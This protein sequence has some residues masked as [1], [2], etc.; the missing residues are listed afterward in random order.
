MSTTTN[1][2]IEKLKSMTLL[3]ASE[4]VSQ[5]EQTFGVDASAP[6]GGNFIQSQG[7]GGSSAQEAQEEKTTFDVILESIP[8]SSR[9]AAF[10]VIRKITNL[11][12]KEVKEFADSLPKPIKEG[13]SKEEAESLKAEL[14]QAG[15]K[16]KIQ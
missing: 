8:D 4:L 3:E 2:I 10:K 6:I 9:I 14:E 7:D 1:E 5:I 16:I 13:I 12:L 15:T 11:G